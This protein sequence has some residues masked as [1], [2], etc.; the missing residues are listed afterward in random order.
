MLLRD[1]IASGCEEP[2]VLLNGKGNRSIDIMAMQSG[3]TDYLVKSEL[4]TEKLERC[5]RYSLERAAALKQLKV[6]EM[7]YRNLFEGAKDAVM[8]TDS[9]LKI[10]EANHAASV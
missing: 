3:A 2:I 7:K 4:S 5:I 10:M 6:R 8:I 1:A 9:S